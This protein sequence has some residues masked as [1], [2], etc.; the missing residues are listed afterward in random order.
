MLQLNPRQK[1]VILY[2][3]PRIDFRIEYF[4]VQQSNYDLK[5]WHKILS[6]NLC[7]YNSKLFIVNMNESILNRSKSSTNTAF[8]N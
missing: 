3:V 4:Y 5:N 8:L 6:I 1:L 7:V 2:E